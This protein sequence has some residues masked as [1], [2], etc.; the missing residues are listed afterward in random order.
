M[1]RVLWINGAFGAGKSTVACELQRRLPRSRILDP[2]TIGFVV[3]R[4]PFR[5]RA[6]YQ[7]SPLWRRSTV[8]AIRAAAALAGTVIVPMTVVDDDVL[9]DV[10]GGLRRRGVDVRMVALV[11]GPDELRE[12]LRRRGSH[13]G[14]GEDQIERCL[15]AVGI[16][17][18]GEPIETEGR[19]V[20]AVADAV[21]AAA[22]A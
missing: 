21:L 3:Q 6:D 7:L 2:E 10:V 17:A 5:R 16:P 14:W 13:G 15:R 1:G 9:D 11:V 8:L 19:S 22:G 4:L 20:P 18:F 12:R